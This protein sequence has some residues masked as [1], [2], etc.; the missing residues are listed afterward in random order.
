MSKKKKGKK[1]TIESIPV[2]VLEKLTQELD[3]SRREHRVKIRTSFVIEV[4]I[5]PPVN[6]GDD[7]DVDVPWNQPEVDSELEKVDANIK[8]HP[9]IS[10]L[11]ENLKKRVDEFKSHLKKVSKEYSVPEEEILDHIDGLSVT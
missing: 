7:F 2:K 10:E 8:V 4:N 9:I 5:S 11:L 3:D 6:E 1:G